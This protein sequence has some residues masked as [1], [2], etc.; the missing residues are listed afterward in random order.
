[1]AVTGTG[2]N[3]YLKSDIDSTLLTGKW[4]ALEW[5]YLQSMIYISNANIQHQGGVQYVVILG[6]TVTIYAVSNCSPD[7]HMSVIWCDTPSAVFVGSKT[8]TNCCYKTQ[9]TILWCDTTA[10]TLWLVL[11]SIVKKYC[12]QTKHKLKLEEWT[13]GVEVSAKQHG[14]ATTTPPA[15]CKQ[16]GFLIKL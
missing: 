15:W 13:C 7:W 16:W 4:K 5:S 10:V 3:L 6:E 8:V 2:H 12:G 9:F 14:D 1:M 11:A